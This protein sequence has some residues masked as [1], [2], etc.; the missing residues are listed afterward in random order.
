VGQAV[1]RGFLLGFTPFGPLSRGSEIDN[2][3]H[4]VARRYPDN[5]A[6]AILARFSCKLIRRYP[7]TGSRQPRVYEALMRGFPV[8]TKGYFFCPL[9]K[10]HFSPSFPAALARL[11]LNEYSQ[12]PD[13]FAVMLKVDVKVK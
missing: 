5:V 1:R 4:E 6:G 8:V 11:I 10:S 12:W 9:A 2:V 7:G 3:A 13:N